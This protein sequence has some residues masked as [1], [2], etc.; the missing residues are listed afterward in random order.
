M[1]QESNTPEPYTKPANHY[2]DNKKFLAALTEYR[3][4]VLEAKEIGAELPPVT[5]YIG[6]CFLKITQHLS[7][8][9]NFIN[10]SYREEMISDAIEN[11]LMA[12]TNF[13]PE[14]GKNPFAYFTQVSYIAFIRRIQKEQKQMQTKYRLIE[15][16]D[17]DAI[18]AQRHDNGEFAT[19]FI[20]HLKKQLEYIDN[21][22]RAAAE[23]KKK[24]E[25]PILPIDES[26]L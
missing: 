3:Q 24:S 6:E 26:P 2:I 7:Y 14:I 11:C 23:N 13:D 5:N 1:T 19:Q 25:H 4:G 16:M 21:N 8:K 22:K 9:S 15:N 12:V 10:Y 18:I 17:I 20:E